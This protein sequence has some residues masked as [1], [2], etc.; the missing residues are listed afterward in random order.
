MIINTKAISVDTAVEMIQNTID[1][2][3]FK[4]GFT[5]TLGKL[6]DLALQQKAETIIMEMR[7]IDKLFVASVEKGVVTLAGST[8]SLKVKEDCEREISRLIGV[9]RVKNDILIVKPISYSV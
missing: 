6:A 9:E 5:E 1:S 3:E 2:P 4:G 7:G 8:D